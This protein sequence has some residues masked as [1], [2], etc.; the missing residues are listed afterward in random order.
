MTYLTKEGLEK[1]RA[2]LTELETEG[3]KKMAREL[4][5]AISFG[6]LREN[7]AYDTAKNN[8]AFM[9]ARIAELKELTR[10]A[11]IV[12]KA[13]SDKIELGST[14][15]VRM[16]SGEKKFRIVDPGEADPMIGKLSYKSPMGEALLG[17][18][19]GKKVIVQ[20]PV[21]EKELEIIAIA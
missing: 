19:K 8:Q 13:S 12:K 7:A 6:D 20:L 16:A 2:E 9:E 4:K 21:G 3:R 15:T 5:H 18:T 10:N 17:E 14:V 11:E 1:L